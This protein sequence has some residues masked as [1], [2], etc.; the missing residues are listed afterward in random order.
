M[1]STPTVVTKV[2]AMGEEHELEASNTQ[3]EG[4][5][6][7][8]Y[9]PAVKA[10]QTEL[11]TGPSSAM[12]AE[13]EE[14]DEE[15]AR[16]A[17]QHKTGADKGNPGKGRGQQS[18]GSGGYG[19][20]RG[21]DQRYQQRWKSDDWHDWQADEAPT[22]SPNVKQMQREIK[23][24]KE[25]VF[26]L[27]KMAL[28]HEDSGNCLK[29]ELSW[30]MFLRLDMRATVVPALYKM[31]EK[32]RE[33]KEKHPEELTNPMRIDLVKALFKE[34]SVRLEALCQQE[35]QMSTLI[36]MGWLQR[37]PMQ[38]HYVKW[39]PEHERLRAEPTRQPVTHAKV[40]AIVGALQ[41][42][43]TPDVVTRFHPSRGI[44][45]H[46]GGKSLTM[47]LQTSIHGEAAETIR[48]HLRTLSGLGATQLLG[49]GVRQD[50]QGRSALAN[51]IQKQI[52]K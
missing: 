20:N 28:R 37:D 52:N 44:V 11:S 48:G 17:K 29:A 7:D 41:Q 34:F 43:A 27:Q 4:L 24:L 33:L 1:A 51:V 30:V 49:M 47:S 26:A 36:N 14:R 38:W 10:A 35:E 32:W 3:R 2:P 18:T 39:D 5:F 19:K 16:A 31:Q 12:E 9:W 23:Q 21:R 22:A 8:Q 45:E 13:D 6:F 50:R 15:K 40:A 46:M 42:L 25:S